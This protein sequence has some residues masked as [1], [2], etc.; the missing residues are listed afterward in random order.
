M[1]TLINNC[2]AVL[3]DGAATILPHAFVTVEGHRIVSVGTERPT[4]VFEDEIDGRGQV[5]LPGLV[6]AHTHVPMSLLRGYGDGHDLQDW[7]N[8][9][10]FPVEAKLDGRAVRA[11]TALGLAE[12]IASGTTTIA[13]MYYFCDE[14]A[15][16]TVAAGLNLNLARGTTVFTSDFDFATYPACVELRALAERW[17]GYGDGQ[18]LVDVGI[19]GEYTSFSAP[20]LWSSLAEYA[21]THGLGMHVHVSETRAEHDECVARHGGKTPI[22]ILNDYGVWDVRA[23]A[24]HCVH[25]TPDDWA[26]MAE[27]GISCVHNPVSN[28]KLGSGVA[29]IPAMKRAGVNI[30]LGTDGVSSNNSHDL[31]EEIKLAAILHNGVARDPLA[32]PAY[33]ALRMA[34]ADGARA[35]GRKTGQIAPGYD[36]DLILVDFSAP[37]LTPCHDIVSNLV[38]AA[39]GS[40]VTMN[41]ARGK[42][43]YKDGTFFTIDLERVRREVAQYAIPLL[44]GRAP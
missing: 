44:F 1:A 38:Y 6:N 20:G 15:E 25:T 18:V 3:M 5:L 40:L 28:L 31:F 17:H 16:E 43:I 42:V 39:R 37:S 11:G 34:T 35:L 32:V 13:D 14:I 24:A 12:M 41:M 27:K 4:G 19:H 36:A 30:A 9:Y 23:I 10:I 26:I 2:T 33:D 21:A 29:P 7:L 22:G 8:N